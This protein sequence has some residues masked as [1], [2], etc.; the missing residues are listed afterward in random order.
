MDAGPS[1]DRD[2]GSD[3]PE[4][5]SANEHAERAS[6]RQ[7]AGRKAAATR[8]ARKEQSRLPKPARDMGLAVGQTWRGKP[9]NKNV[10]KRVVEIAS[11]DDT[12][13]VPRIVSA[14]T[15][16]TAAKHMTFDHLRKCYEMSGGVLR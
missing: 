16:R 2:D 9:Y 6:V 11:I 8:K 7:R 13:V 3:D 10:A 1:A 15:D 4:E 14:G 5:T 12:G